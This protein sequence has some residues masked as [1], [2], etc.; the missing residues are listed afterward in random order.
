LGLRLTANDC[1]AI[2]FAVP[3]WAISADTLAQQSTIT[4]LKPIKSDV[5]K[6]QEQ[7]FADSKSRSN[8]RKR[9]EGEPASSSKVT[10]EDLEKLWNKQ[11]GMKPARDRGNKRKIESSPAI[12]EPSPH[13]DAHGQARPTKNVT[14]KKMKKSPSEELDK[15]PGKTAEETEPKTPHG[16]QL[17]KVNGVPSKTTEPAGKIKEALAPLDSTTKSTPHK[18]MKRDKKDKHN[19]FSRPGAPSSKAVLPPS[20]PTRALLPPPPPPLAASKLT[21]LQAKM[22]SKLTSAR[23]RHLNQTLYT[24]TS[25]SALQLFTTSPDLFAEY[26]AGFSQQVRD[27]WPLNPVD[28]YIRAVKTR[29]AISG[30]SN[31]T[32]ASNAT[33]VSSSSILPLPRRKT[34]SCTLAD[35]G[36]GDAPLA[37]GCQSV[38]KTLNLKFHSFDLHAPNTHVTVAD[39][40]NLPLRDGEADVCVFCL[41]L[42]GTNWVGFVEECWR[43]LRGDGKGEVWVAEV[44]SRFGRVGSHKGRKGVVVEN[45][46][47]K[48]RKVQAQ[49]QQ[50]VDDE[51]VLA[52]VDGADTE[53]GTGDETDI[54]AFVAV[55]ARRGFELRPE[56]V[57]KGNKMFV[58]MVFVKSG[59]PTAGKHKGKKWNGKEYRVVHDGKMKFTQE[60]EGE[61]EV[62]PSVE[63]AVLKPCVYKIR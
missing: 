57:S 35:L 8:K 2:M 43:V 1:I 6:S 62:D 20:Q 27:S 10:A 37:R 26:H 44:K 42:M 19:D 60:Q 50:K 56:S 39:I 31:S 47:G 7:A 52:E 22:R 59:V 54:S 15:A 28:V 38:I 40:A 29:G 46:V 14:P 34:G 11:F 32:S 21:P 45:S 58:S 4:P 12:V 30:S 48:K 51:S 16:E 17:R 23:F 36:C 61:G 49:Q 13:D 53:T 18:E 33:T 25:T 63:A 41:S 3:G 9:S 55:F 24:T 5:Q